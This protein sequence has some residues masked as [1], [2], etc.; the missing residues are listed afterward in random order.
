MSFA[1]T[2]RHSLMLA[3]AALGAP[4]AALAKTPDSAS[5]VLPE[6]PIAGNP[7]GDLTIVDFYDIRCPPCRAM[8][9][10]IT[11]LIAADHGIRYVPIDYPI[12]GPASLLGTQAL[13][14]AQIQ[15]QYFPLRAKLMTEPAPPTDVS[16]EAD[17]K[18]L[19]L[20]WAAMELAMNGDEVAHRVAMNL[21]RGK[22]LGVTGI[23]TLFI[24]RQIVPGSLSYADLVSVV[25]SAR[26]G[27]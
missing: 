25:A 14:A 4:S 24:G 19:R 2:R 20:D 27:A 23:P 16:I 9:P 21:A 11:R 10:R 5:L 7:K 17:A 15:G 3:L 22:K 6:D 12:L 13:F 8:D 26:K 1:L 18:T